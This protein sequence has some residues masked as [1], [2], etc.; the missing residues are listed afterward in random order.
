MDLDNYL[1]YRLLVVTA[2]VT[3]AYERRYERDFGISIPES[4]VLNVIGQHKV[5][6]STEICE[7]TTMTKSRVSMAVNRL[8]AA[9]LLTREGD[10]NDQRV[11]R[12]AFSPEGEAL[13]RRM[14]P[15]ALEM[16]SQL[17][18]SFGPKDRATF[19]KLLRAIEQTL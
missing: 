14:V 8:V 6:N 18:A 19:M 3:Q 5:L 11:A 16:E 13:Y 4:R 17:T 2:R 1:P 7:L 12:L 9:G 15:V 10:A